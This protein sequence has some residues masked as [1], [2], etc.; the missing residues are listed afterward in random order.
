MTIKKPDFMTKAPGE[1]TWDDITDAGK[2]AA[3]LTAAQNRDDARYEARVQKLKKEYEEKRSR[4][5]EQ[6]DVLEQ[7]AR[8]AFDNLKSQLGTARSIENAWCKIGYRASSSLSLRYRVTEEK[9]VENAQ[10]LVESGALSKDVLNVKTTINKD[11]LKKLGDDLLKK[12]G[13]RR[14]PDDIFFFKP[15]TGPDSKTQ[16]RR[17]AK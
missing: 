4:R 7:L 5:K 9:A 13:Y 6:Y 12:I 11:A 17:A 3:K 16:A 8:Q 15:K 1:W 14:S 2:A 10:A